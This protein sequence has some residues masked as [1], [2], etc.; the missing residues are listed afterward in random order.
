[1]DIAEIVAQ[2]SHDSETQVGSVLVRNSN[3]TLVSTG[4]NGFVAGAPDSELPTTRPDKYEYIVHSELNLISN[5][6][7]NSIS[8][9]DCYVVCTLSP[10]AQCTRMLLNAGITKVIAKSLYKDFY[11]SVMNMRDIAV[12]CHQQEDGFYYITYSPR[13]P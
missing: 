7:K 11:P 13:I 2:R 1:M 6:A 10:C 8:T 3:H 12:G 9:D 4:F 5:C